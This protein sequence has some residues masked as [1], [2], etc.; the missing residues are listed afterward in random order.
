LEPFVFTGTAGEP[1]MSADA[2][3]CTPFTDA[4]LTPPEESPTLAIAAISDDRLFTVSEISSLLKVRKFDVY[5]ACDRGH[6]EYVKFEGAVQVE[7]R[8]LKRWVL[9]AAS[10]PPDLR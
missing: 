7:G 4:G 10:T 2:S 8:D 3:K 1:V 6:L 5:R 9:S